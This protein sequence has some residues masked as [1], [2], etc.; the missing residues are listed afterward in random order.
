MGPF[1]DSSNEKIKAGDL[2][3]TPAELFHTQFTENIHDFLEA[4]PNS[5]VLVV[6]SV[7][8][9]ISDRFVYPQ[10]SLDA[11]GLFG[12]PVSQSWFC[13]DCFY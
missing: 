9:M 11:P 8:D 6:P 10:A 3:Q 13:V 12:H 4:S 7:R 2:D 1:L 5:L